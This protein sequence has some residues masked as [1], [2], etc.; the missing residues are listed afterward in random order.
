MRKRAQKPSVSAYTKWA[1]AGGVASLAVTSVQAIAPEDVL[2]FSKGPVTLR[3]QLDLTEQYNDNIFFRNTDREADFLSIISPGLEFEVGRDENFMRL[4]YSWDNFFY[5]DNDELNADQHRLR[6]QNSLVLDD[7]SVTGRDNIEFLSSVLSGGSTVRN[8]VVDRAIYRDEY[9][10]KYDLGERTAVYFEGLHHTTDFDHPALFDSNT[11]MG[12]LGFT[13]KAFSK[14]SLFSE[15]YYGQTARN[16]NGPGVKPPWSWNL[17]GFIGARGD[18]TEKLTGTAKAG[19][20]TR[21][22]ADGV[23]G[24]SS[25]VVSIGLTEAFT[26]KSTLRLTYTRQTYVS[27]E[28]LRSQ[29]TAD[30]VDLAFT[31]WIG[32][33]GRFKGTVGGYYNRDTYDGAQPAV[34]GPVE[35]ADDL[36]RA[37]L[38]LNYDLS[39]WSSLLLGYEFEKFSSSHPG[40]IDYHA[41]RVTLTVAFGY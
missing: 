38:T 20:E 36:W 24:A 12:S 13:W 29:F 26:E 37:Y 41:N 1:I 25:P 3:P 9:T 19:Y 4:D 35:R 22:F 6:F 28:F 31:Q 27:T 10:L 40:V 17:G 15:V 33:D 32:N 2:V 39:R 21:E 16:V 23:G 8:T 34:G 5:A 14:T 30:V 7:F 11:L 18:F